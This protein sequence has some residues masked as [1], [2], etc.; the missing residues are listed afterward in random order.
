MFFIIYA[1]LHLPAM[2]C[3]WD[4]DTLAQEAEGKLDVVLTSVGWF[5]RHPPLYYEMRLSRVSAA[6]R[7]EQGRLEHYDDA[8]VACDRLGRQD[9]AIFWMEQKKKIMDSLPPAQL[10]AHPYRYL[11][12]LGTFHAHRWVRSKDRGKNLAD[13]DTAIRLVS[14]AIEINPAAHFNREP[15]QL[16]L[17][18]W[19]R[20]GFQGHEQPEK[21]NGSLQPLFVPWDKRF[22]ERPGFDLTQSLCG[23]I[24]LGAAWESIDVYSWLVYSL[25]SRGNFNQ[26]K[27]P[28][29][30]ML[31]ALRCS[32]LV[33]SDKRHPLHPHPDFQA[34]CTWSDKQLARV[35]EPEELPGGY[36]VAFVVML[37]GRPE[38]T[39]EAADGIVEFFEQ[40]KR[41]ADERHQAKTAYTLAKLQRGEH[42]D[43][44]PGFWHE[45][46]EPPAPHLP[47]GTVEEMLFGSSVDHWL[48][49]HPAAKLWGMV[50]LSALAILSLT[51]FSLRWRQKRTVVTPPR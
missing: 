15:G 32:E 30:A 34:F 40:A 6:I 3:L 16:L 12:N 24:Q 28:S 9:E 44:H 20:D 26:E 42:P 10:G 5:D 1:C 27:S 29:L 14:E 47:S 43:T 45:W 23:I 19:L 37:C 38:V 31:P 51:R 13:L 7:Q 11:A 4:S 25:G 46:K 49:N 50:A 18:E 22:R 33:L 21:I 2:A 17:L 8:A 36:A 41:A 39:H 35:K 48:K